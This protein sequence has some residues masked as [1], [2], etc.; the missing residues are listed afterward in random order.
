MA[1]VT[2]Y[3]EVGDVITYTYVATNIGNVTLTN[4]SITD[5]MPAS[6]H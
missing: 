4:V 1:D 3:D 5:P 6:V 2:T